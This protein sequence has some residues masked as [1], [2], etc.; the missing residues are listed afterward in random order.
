MSRKTEPTI[1]LVEEALVV[2]KQPVVTGRVRVATK[3]ETV[4]EIAALSLAQQAVSV[5]RVAVDREIEQVPPVRT[6][7]DVTII[8]VVEEVMVV[9]K[10]LV[11]KEELRITR[12]TTSERVEV[13]VTLRKQRAEIER[14]G[15]QDPTGPEP[16]IEEDE[17]K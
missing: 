8:P 9:E 3:T 16:T 5:E 15:P 10:R 17:F 7:G 13:P 6:E 2:D 14:L 1:P 11:L 4:E 12:Q